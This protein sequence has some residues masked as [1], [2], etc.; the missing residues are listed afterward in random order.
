[1]LFFKCKIGRTAKC[2]DFGYVKQHRLIAT[3]ISK[4][5]IFP[6]EVMLQWEIYTVIYG[7]TVNHSECCI[8]TQLAL[9]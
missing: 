6:T 7:S 9:S 2:T 8:I 4:A 1:M 5:V 3:S